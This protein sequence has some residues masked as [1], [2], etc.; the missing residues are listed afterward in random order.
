[1]VAELDW[2]PGQCDL[3]AILRSAVQ[4]L[5]FYLCKFLRSL[6]AAC[7][8]GVDTAGLR[9]PARQAALDW[10]LGT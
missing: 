10:C 2:R 8:N 6:H 7:Q 9:L 4:E 5:L 1:M 3:L